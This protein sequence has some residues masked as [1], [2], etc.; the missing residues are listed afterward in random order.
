MKSACSMLKKAE[1]NPWVGPNFINHFSLAHNKWIAD[2][3]NF[4]LL[5]YSKIWCR[6]A[7]FQRKLGKHW[8]PSTMWINLILKRDKIF[9]PAL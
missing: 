6:G 2:L 8:H 7:D 9:E 4:C 1:R 3:L 5:L